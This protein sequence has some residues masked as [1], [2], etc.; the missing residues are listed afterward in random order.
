MKKWFAA[1]ICFVLIGIC[2]LLLWGNRAVAATHFT[3]SSERLPKVFNGYRIAQISDLHNTALGKDH[4]KLLKLLAKQN[5]D[6]I[7]ITGDMID[8]RST[9]VDIALSF[10]RQAV[11]LAPIYYVPGNHEARVTDAYRALK[12]GLESAGVT[13]LENQSV[14]IDRDGASITLCGVTDPSMQYGM[15]DA[16]YL[17]GVLG[18]LIADDGYTLLLSHRPEL[19]D[20]Y[21]KHGVDL[22]FTGHA[23]GGQIRLPFIG[24]IV[25]PHQGLF[26]QYYAG[27]FTDGRTQMIVSRGIGN[28]LFP[29]RV[30]NRPELVVATLKAE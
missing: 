12:T 14:R 3:V 13:V 23:H 8:S 29:L 20:I 6:L 4:Q 1:A 16:D 18:E 21:R 11:Q 15:E 2:L 7:V 17:D 26:P 25:A 30:N 28:S 24:G 5:P 9:D 27:I 19:F 22:V 10:A